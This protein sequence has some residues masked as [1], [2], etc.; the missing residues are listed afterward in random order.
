MSNFCNMLKL[1]SIY[2]NKTLLENMLFTSVIYHFLHWFLTDIESTNF[3]SI[4]V[5]IGFLKLM[6]T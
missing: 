5:N 1:Y 2:D 4:I 6:L 3:E